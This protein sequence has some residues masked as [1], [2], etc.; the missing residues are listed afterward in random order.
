[1]HWRWT[2]ADVDQWLVVPLLSGWVISYDNLCEN[3]SLGVNPEDLAE[4]GR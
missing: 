1:M 4:F 2:G 3:F